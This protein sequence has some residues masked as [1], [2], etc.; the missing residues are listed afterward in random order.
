MRKW[1]YNFDSKL[2]YK[3]SII[4][5]FVNSRANLQYKFNPEL[6]TCIS[7]LLLIDTCDT[8]RFFW[9]QMQPRHTLRITS[10]RQKSRRGLCKN[11]I[12]FQSCSKCYR[13]HYC[14]SSFRSSWSLL[15]YEVKEGMIMRKTIHDWNNPCKILL[16]PLEEWTYRMICNWELTMIGTS[17]VW[18]GTSRGVVSVSLR[19]GSARHVCWWK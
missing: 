9:L 1:N 11:C 5:C 16:S 17:T 12:L 14:S 19:V 6:Q 13:C 8:M 15:S 3:Y 4:W 7:F 2:F 10:F 18:V